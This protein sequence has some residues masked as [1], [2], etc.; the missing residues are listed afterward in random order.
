MSD[1]SEVE[2]SLCGRG[3]GSFPTC[4]ICHGGAENQTKAFTLSDHRAGRAPQENRYDPEGGLQPSSSPYV[5]GGA[6]NHPG[7]R[8]N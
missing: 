1:Q 8:Q 6:V 5:V 7:Q 2:C 4:E 3:G